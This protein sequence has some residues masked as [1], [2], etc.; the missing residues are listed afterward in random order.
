MGFVRGEK[1]KTM[2]IINFGKWRHKATGLFL[3][4]RVFKDGDKWTPLCMVYF[5]YV[6]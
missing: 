4:D 5:R 2:L 6:G 3:Y 1:G